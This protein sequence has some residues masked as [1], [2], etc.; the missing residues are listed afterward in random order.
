[1]DLVDREKAIEVLRKI[2]KERAGCN[3]GRKSIDQANALGYAIM[4][5]KKLPRVETEKKQ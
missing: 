5:L 1:M 3:C 4:I 2:Q